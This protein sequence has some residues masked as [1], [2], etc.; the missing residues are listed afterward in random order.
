MSPMYEAANTAPT[1]FTRRSISADELRRL[2]APALIFEGTH[3]DAD[4]AVA[5]LYTVAGWL[6]GKN[7]A[8][9]QGGCT[10][11]GDVILIHARNRDEADLMAGLGLQD[12][13]DALN[14]E[15]DRY[16]DALAAQARLAA[17]NPLRRTELSMVPD[18]QKNSD[19]VSD[20]EKLRPLV[21][22]DIVLSAAGVTRH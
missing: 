18:A 17:I 3:T 7:I 1:F 20:T 5:Y 11:G 22:D 2:D 16:L 10:V 6:D 9:M 8:T 12:T 15:E 4:G 14:A 21:G 19:F 13:I